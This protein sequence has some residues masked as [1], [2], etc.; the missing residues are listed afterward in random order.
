MFFKDFIET[1][2]NFLQLLGDCKN[3]APLKWAF[4]QNFVK[5]VENDDNCITIGLYFLISKA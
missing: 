5:L 4:L 3:T 1:L 2:N